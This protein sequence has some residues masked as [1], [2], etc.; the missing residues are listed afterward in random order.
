MCQ[1]KS[2]EPQFHVCML[3]PGSRFTRR[4]KDAQSGM[5]GQTPSGKSYGTKANIELNESSVTIRVRAVSG[6]E[7]ELLLHNSWQ[8]KEVE[9]LSASEKG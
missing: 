9:A 1:W 6:A 5:F 4:N 7:L 8:F 3:G 2:F